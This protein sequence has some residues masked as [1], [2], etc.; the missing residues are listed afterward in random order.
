MKPTQFYQWSHYPTSEVHSRLIP[1][2]PCAHPGLQGRGRSRTGILWSAH[3]LDY[4]NPGALVS[5][6]WNRVV[7]HQKSTTTGNCSSVAN[8]EATF[9]SSTEL[10]FLIKR[11][12]AKPTRVIDS[13]RTPLPSSPFL[14]LPSP[15]NSG[16]S[17]P[18]SVLLFPQT[19]SASTTAL[20]HMTC[21][22]LSLTF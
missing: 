2:R 21:G 6:I 3:I 1:N 22:C 17:G 7:V 20:R 14:F 12:L 4:K 16:S 13:E 11:R 5:L 8:A 15:L 18:V 19:L 10:V 9:L